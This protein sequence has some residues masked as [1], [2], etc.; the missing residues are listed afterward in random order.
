MRNA[1]GDSWDVGF[2]N[3]P[4]FPCRSYGAWSRNEEEPF[5]YKHAAPNGANF[6]MTFSLLAPLRLCAFALKG[7]SVSFWP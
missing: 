4:E 6:R 5:C 2:G 1:L 3:L 7:P